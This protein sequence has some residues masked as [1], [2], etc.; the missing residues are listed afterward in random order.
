MLRH[1]FGYGSAIQLS[2]FFGTAL[3]SIDRVIAGFLFGPQGI[4]LFEL[5]AKLPMAANSVPSA[6]SNVTMPAVSR[7]FANNDL[8]GIRDI[9]RKTSRSTSLISAIPLGFMAAFAGPIS[10][11][12]LGNRADL[13]QLPL[14]LTLTAIWSHLH[15][16]TGPGSAVFRGIGKVGNEFVYH[17]LRMIFLAVIIACCVLT[18]GTSITSLTLGL[19]GGSAM[20]ALCYL[21]YNQQRMGLPLQQLLREIIAPGFVVYP[22]AYALLWASQILLP[23]GLSR[24]EELIALFLCGALYCANVGLISWKFILLDYERESINTLWKRLCVNTLKWRRA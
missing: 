5:A 10:L 3:F 22:I 2:T 19:A 8:D 15:I 18:M 12:W 1:F 6:I 17:L 13:Q 21:L 9:Y 14:I 16:I 20:S 23:A 7:L 24:W 4:A 11:A